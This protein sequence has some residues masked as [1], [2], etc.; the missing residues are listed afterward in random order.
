MRELDFSSLFPFEA[1]LLFRQ[2]LQ[3]LFLVS[4]KRFSLPRTGA[5]PN[6]PKGE[7]GNSKI[8]RRQAKGRQTPAPQKQHQ[9]SPLRT[10]GC[11]NNKFAPRR[12]KEKRGNTKNS[13]AVHTS[14]RAEGRQTARPESKNIAPP[15]SKGAA[16]PPP[17]KT[18]P[19]ISPPNEK[20]AANTPPLE[21]NKK[22]LL[23]ATARRRDLFAK[24]SCDRGGPF[25]HF[26]A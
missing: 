6:A 5:A 20:G 3:L 2:K 17:P 15:P 21:N 23:R 8:R 18:T 11:G 16:Q 12:D 24:F 9:T 13:P 1:V 10:K 14:G 25:R 26:S 19:N 4:G 22:Q 7:R